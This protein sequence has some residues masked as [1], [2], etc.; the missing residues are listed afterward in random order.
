MKK[1]LVALAITAALA[2][3]ACSQAQYFGAPP[4][5][6]SG[7]YSGLIAPASP[8]GGYSGGYYG[9][10]AKPSGPIDFSNLSGLSEEQKRQQE[11]ARE[12]SQSPYPNMNPSTPAGGSAFEAMIAE[13]EKKADEIRKQQVKTLKKQLKKGQKKTRKSS[14]MQNLLKQYQEQ[15]SA[16][17]A[18]VTAKQLAKLK[19]VLAAEGMTA[20]NGGKAPMPA[21]LPPMPPE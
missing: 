3:P 4:S 6:P 19:A 2:W 17:G 12:L 5:G 10:Q 21:G 7:G 15:E 18:A 8:Q 13:Q 9:Q 1:S 11:T 20:G 14:E 16:A